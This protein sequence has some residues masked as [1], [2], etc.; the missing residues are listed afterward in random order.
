MPAPSESRCKQGR[1]GTSFQKVRESTRNSD[2]GW[3][4]RSPID[5]ATEAVRDLS[6]LAFI[7]TTNDDALQVLADRCQP[8]DELWFRG[9][10]PNREEPLHSA[11]QAI[12]MAR[13]I[14]WPHELRF[15]SERQRKLGNGWAPL[16]QVLKGRARHCFH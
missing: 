10:P 14:R 9:S 5:T 16:I 1:E 7:Y 15:T 2:R 3:V 13:L 11:S 6:I 12:E 8:R 4:L